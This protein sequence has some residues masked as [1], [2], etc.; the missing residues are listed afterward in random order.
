ME[1]RK[2]ARYVADLARIDISSEE[3]KFLEEQLSRILEYIDKLKEVD[4][5]GIEP[6]RGLHSQKN[7]FRKDQAKIYPFRNDIIANAPLKDG[8]FFK[9]PPVID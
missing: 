3:E 4:V 9:I 2:I 7:F 1:E 5:D 6:M 8:N